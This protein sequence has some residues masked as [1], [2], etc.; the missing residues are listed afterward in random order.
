MSPG[1]C[2]CFSPFGRFPWTRV[3]GQLDGVLSMVCSLVGWLVVKEY[4]KVGGYR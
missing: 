4:K 2:V 3:D 1:V